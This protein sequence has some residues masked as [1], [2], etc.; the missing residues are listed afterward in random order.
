M[1]IRKKQMGKLVMICALAVSMLTGIAVAE[2]DLA[3]VLKNPTSILCSSAKAEKNESKLTK[4]EKKKEAKKKKSDKKQ[5]KEAGKKDQKGTA[6]QQKNDDLKDIAVL[7]QQNTADAEVQSKDLLTRMAETK[8][9]SKNAV[10]NI[11]AYLKYENAALNKISAL[12]NDGKLKENMLKTLEHF[13]EQM[14]K[15]AVKSG[16][17]ADILFTRSTLQTMLLEKVITQDEHDAIV[18]QLTQDLLEAAQKAQYISQ[19]E[20][21]AAKP[22]LT[23]SANNG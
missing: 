20:L 3:D 10:D 13:V 6:D 11:N 14:R 17:A 8:V 16:A 23:K 19:A 2:V 9:L 12:V 22:L 21:E 5:K 18:S 4:G 1:K 15:D 7:F